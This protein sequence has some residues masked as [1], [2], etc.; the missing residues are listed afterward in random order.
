M[1]QTVRRI[2]HRC[3]FRLAI[4]IVGAAVINA[5]INKLVYEKDSVGV[6]WAFEYI[7]PFRIMEDLTK[8]GI[9][10]KIILEF[11]NIKTTEEGEI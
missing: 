5:V 2:W 1:S 8:H 9:I 6:V 4:C 10:N 3:P 11:D 7:D